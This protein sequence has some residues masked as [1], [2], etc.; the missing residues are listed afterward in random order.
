MNML[1]KLLSL[2]FIFPLLLGAQVKKYKISNELHEISG[3]EIWNDTI[4]IAINDSGNEAILFFMNLKGKIIHKLKIDNAKNHDWEDLTLDSNNNIYI[5][6]VGNNANKRQNLMIYYFSLDSCLFKT[7]ITAKKISF[8][9][10]DQDAFPPE[11][12]KKYFDCEAIAYHNGFLYLFTK[13]LASPF[14]GISSCYQL[15]IST[16]NQ[17]AKKWFTIELPKHRKQF[18]DAITSATIFNQ[19][20]YLLSYSDIYTFKFGITSP[21]IKK[22]KSFGLLSQKEAICVDEN[23]I[24]VAN[25]RSAFY[26]KQKLYKFKRHEH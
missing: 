9:Y 15:T 6:D 11:K 10:E 17:I 23:A 4:L 3:I 22:I 20:C 5:A 8:R 1:I 25:E 13:D 16:E 26:R 2:L 24:F 18:L 19:T 7:S 21:E 14:K 12:D